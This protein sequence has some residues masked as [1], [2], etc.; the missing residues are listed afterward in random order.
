MKDPEEPRISQYEQLGIDSSKGSV[1]KTFKVV[2]DNEFPGA[3]V[4]MITD[5]SSPDR[6]VTQHSDGPGSKLVQNLMH[7]FEAKDATVLGYLIDDAL[8]MN[9][10]DIGSAGFVFQP[11]VVTNTININKF[12]FPEG[13]KEILMEEIAQR[14]LE[15]KELYAEN[16]FDNLNFNRNDLKFLGGETAD[17]PDQV[18]SLVFDMTISAW[19]DKKNVIKGNV[20]PGDKIWGFVSDGRAKW[21]KI[22]NSG[23]MS[24]GLTKARRDLMHPLYNKRYPWAH[25][26]GEF[27]KG[28]YR[29]EDF[30]ESLG[31]TAG[32]ALISPTRQWPILIRKLMLILQEHKCLD[33]LHGISVN[34]GGGATKIKNLGVGGIEY[35]KHMPIPSSIF[36]LIQEESQE[37]WEKMYK[38]F[39]CGFG[40][41]IVG[42]KDPFFEKILKIVEEECEVILFNLGECQEFAGEGNKVTLDTHFGEFV[43]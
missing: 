12:A 39:N 18:R 1:R 6:V 35:V 28:K 22:N 9:G 33:M 27:F 14:L 42:K 26:D 43:Y 29:I 3:W 40:I 25:R 7:Y 5:P 41:D 13:F 10:S 38:T 8:S 17:L 32:Q 31:M 4:N 2:N 20:Q 34:T 11:W 23:L 21:E 30:V 37:E 19:A 24:N 36:Q 16:G 15:L